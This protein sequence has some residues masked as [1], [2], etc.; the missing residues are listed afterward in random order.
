MDVLISL[1]HVPIAMAVALAIL[2][3]LC[4]GRHVCGRTAIVLS[5][6][7]LNGGEVKRERSEVGVLSLR[8]DKFVG[9]AKGRC[10]VYTGETPAGE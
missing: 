5:R 4:M 2:G 8:P 3:T 1:G 9:K 6:S 10:W 7:R